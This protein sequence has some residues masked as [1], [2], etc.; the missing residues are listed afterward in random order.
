MSSATVTPRDDDDVGS[1]GDGT[2]MDE[3]SEEERESEEMD[4]NIHIRGFKTIGRV[5]TQQEEKQEMD[6]ATPE[7]DEGDSA[8]PGGPP[9]CDRRRRGGGR[10][11]ID[12]DAS[13]HRDRA[14]LKRGRVARYRDG[15]M[16]V[17]DQNRMFGL[18][19]CQTKRASFSGH[20][21]MLRFIPSFNAA[22]PSLVG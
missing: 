18:T 22:Y 15:E 10:G 3:L 21:S 17:D 6:E 2:P 7:D 8:I 11:N 12:M 20:P 13:I 14:S 9:F 1:D 16:G 5:K 4:N 19:R